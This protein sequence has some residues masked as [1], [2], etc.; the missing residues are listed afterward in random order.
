M[1]GLVAGGVVASGLDA[2][3][4]SL[5][6]GGDLAVQLA[7]LEQNGLRALIV[8][9]IHWMSTGCSSQLLSSTLG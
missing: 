9:C 3:T 4:S 2:I 1:S 5:A 8:A 6:G 7:G